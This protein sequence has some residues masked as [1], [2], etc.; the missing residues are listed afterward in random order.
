MS[1]L[2]LTPLP[3]IPRVEPG[4]DLVAIL[5]AATAEAEIELVDADVLVV[6]QKIVSKAEN[7]Y[8][9]LASVTP[10]ASARTLALEVDKDPRLVELI[11]SEAEE[12]V[13]YRVGVLVVAHRLGFVLANAGIDQS[14]IEHGGGEGRV[15]LLPEDPDASAAELRRRIGE[16]TGADVGVIINDSLGRAWRNGTV[17]VAIGAAGVDCLRDLRGD[18]DLFGRE[19]RVTEVGVGDELAAA[20]S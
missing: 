8:V 2:T 9:E 3:G 15:L 17:G 12:V 1:A 11:L 20:G 18:A 13:R 14:N 7:R 19:L 5:L 6:A 10:S 16:E 4:D